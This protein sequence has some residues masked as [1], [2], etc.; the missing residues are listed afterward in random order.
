MTSPGQ[1]IRSRPLALLIAAFAL[2]ALAAGSASALVGPGE[3]RHDS[4]LPF[5][6]NAALSPGSSENTSVIVQNN[7]RKSATI[8]M[9]FY[10]PGGVLIPLASQIHTDVPAWGT[11]TLDQA[12]NQG[13]LPGFRGVGVISSDQPLNAL[14]LREVVG[15][16]NVRSYAIHNAHAGS[17]VR[18]ALPY[19]A[20]QLAEGNSGATINTRFSIA[21]A[22]LEVACV[23]ITYEPLPGRGA[24]AAGGGATLVASG[25]PSES[26]PDGGLA[27]PVAGQLTLAPESGDMA[28]AMPAGTVNSLMS[29]MIDSTQPVTV[30][31]DI[32]RGDSGSARLGSYNGF[33][34]MADG[35]AEDDVSRQMV[36]PL[37]QKT[38]DGYWTE[39]AIAN[40][41]NETVRGS[42]DYSG[43]VAG[44]ANRE[45][46]LTVDFEL[47]AGGGVTHSVLDSGDLPTGFTGWALVEADL[48]V[49]ALLLR[50]KTAGSGSGHSYSAANGAPS[51]GTSTSAKFPLVFRNAH[52]EG[53]ARGYN[54]WVSV[55]VADGGTATLRIIAVNNP[56][57]GAEGCETLQLYRTT[58]TIT[59]SFLFDQ[60]SSDESATGLGDLPE[61]LT[62]GMAITSDRPIAAIGGVTSDL[63]TGDNDGLYNAF[64]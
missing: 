5:Q 19:V 41:W 33:V 34:V 8:V 24:T 48:P 63:E 17:G 38:A 55:A 12:L 42:I 61:C 35:S 36:M 47:P 44:G 56:N 3:P 30:A 2:L 46:T 25:V 57:S 16:D 15:A 23:T 59:G 14:L 31:A 49:A 10:T 21:N 1:R 40:P 26:C 50:G 32:Y 13:L 6:V 22:G 62:G 28:V 29:V 11:L 27:V 7:S 39:F 53:A 18:V 9:D 52:G 54:S 45:V 58:F 4:K 43:T 60:G 20:N 64:Q 37:A 51:E